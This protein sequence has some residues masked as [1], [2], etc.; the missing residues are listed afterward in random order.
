VAESGSFPYYA[1]PALGA[2]APS[3]ADVEAVRARQRS[4]G[5]PEAFEWVDETTPGL[6]PVAEAAGLEVLRAPL[7]VLD[8]ARFGGPTRSSD[9]VVRLLEPSDA[10]FRDDLAVRRAVAAVAFTS[11]GTAV[12]DPGPAERDAALAPVSTEDAAT[13]A[14]AVRAGQFAFALAEAPGE[15]AIGSGAL[16]RAGDVAEIVGVA[17]LP[18]AR[19]RG[20][21]AAVTAA[22]VREAL[23]A[24]SALVFLS[25]GDEA[26]ARIYARL[27]FTRVGTAC[28]AQPAA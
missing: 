23:E 1:R 4:L 10:R 9:V 19:R 15:G 20:V 13:E 7:M 27:G 11:V 6:L 21:G 17:T 26:T 5:V 12:G 8:P 18:S 24:G 2:A 25:A 3:A 22:L 16:Q 14:E 28:I